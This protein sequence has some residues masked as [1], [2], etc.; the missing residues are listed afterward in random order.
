M[1]YEHE[2]S[3]HINVPRSPNY[4]FPIEFQA[5]DEHSNPIPLSFLSGVS[6]LCFEVISGLTY[7]M[8]RDCVSGHFTIN[9]SGLGLFEWDVQSGFFDQTG[10]YEGKVHVK[11][12]GMRAFT[13]DDLRI[14]IVGRP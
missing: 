2:I 1:S 13:L 5:V 12:S 9:N 7:R 3:V 10:V 14:S 8:W 6:G 11:M 4:G